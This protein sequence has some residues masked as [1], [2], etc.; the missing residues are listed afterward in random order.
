[1]KVISSLK[2]R[3]NGNCSVNSDVVCQKTPSI[4]QLYDV[5]NSELAE[6]H[7]STVSPFLMYSVLVVSDLAARVGGGCGLVGTDT[8]LL[9]CEMPLAVLT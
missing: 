9:C 1:M 4:S 8:M 5:A 6:H 3:S 2:P 7:I